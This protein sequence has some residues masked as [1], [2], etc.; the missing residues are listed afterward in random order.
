[1]NKED[2]K[3]FLE[4]R[5][6]STYYNPDYW[7]HEKTIVDKSRQDFTN[8]GMNLEDA[9]NFEVNNE[10]PFDGAYGCMRFREGQWFIFN[11]LA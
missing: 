11:N 5:G 6:W 7:V 4:E 1:M 3:K 2:K 9:Y 8:Y 10:K